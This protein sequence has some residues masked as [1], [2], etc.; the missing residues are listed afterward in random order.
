[1]KVKYKKSNQRSQSTGITN[2]L[3][4]D[5]KDNK[6][7][8]KEKE[9]ESKEKMEKNNEIL[10]IRNDK[11]KRLERLYNL[12]IEED[13]KS[14]NDKYNRIQNMKEQQ[15]KINERKREVKD[16]IARRKREYEEQFS[17]KRRK[18]RFHRYKKRA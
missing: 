2:P 17:K 14:I 6:E 3:Q 1:M 9:K 18:I 7:K 5:S 13:R 16:E 11:I 12:K 10:M 4:K 8:E 15:I